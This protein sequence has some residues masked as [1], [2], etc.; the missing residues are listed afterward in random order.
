MLDVEH[1]SAYGI[2]IEYADCERPYYRDTTQP[3]GWRRNYR[4]EALTA[5]AS[6]V[7]LQLAA[8]AVVEF[9]PPNVEDALLS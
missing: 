1:R 6:D 9:L 5:P 7:L 2:A 4:D 8:L 3:T